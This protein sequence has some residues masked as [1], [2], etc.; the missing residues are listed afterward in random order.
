MLPAHRI[1]P[2][3]RVFP[4]V[5]RSSTIVI[6]RTTRGG[7][8]K[9]PPGSE[10]STC[11][12][13]SQSVMLLNLGEVPP[14]LKLLVFE[15]ACRGREGWREGKSWFESRPGGLFQRLGSAYIHLVFKLTT[16][17]L[18]TSHVAGSIFLNLSRWIPVSATEC[19][20]PSIQNMRCSLRATRRSSPKLRAS[21]WT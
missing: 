11:P 12:S 19:D 1:C 18:L 2:C 13:L 9:L 8:S 17:N 6:H 20:N 4:S 10:P 3:P 16:N 5:S 21:H 14:C 15:H 7:S